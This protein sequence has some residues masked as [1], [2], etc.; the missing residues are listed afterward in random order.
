[1]YKGSALESATNSP[2]SRQADS[3][4][5]S[6]LGAQMRRQPKAE[7]CQMIINVAQLLARTPSNRPALLLARGLG[8]LERSLRGLTGGGLRGQELTGGWS[9]RQIILVCGLARTQSLALS[10]SY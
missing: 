4:L 2:G 7:S 3:E 5:I 10:S 1:M 6:L 9:R 8:L